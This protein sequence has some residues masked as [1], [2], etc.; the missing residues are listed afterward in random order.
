[1]RDPDRIPVIIE[2]LKQYWQRYPDLRLGQIVGNFTPRISAMEP[3][4]S[5]NVE[6]D[7]IEESLRAELRKVRR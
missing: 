2:L 4:S 7:V 6:D 1:M 3:G 5:Y